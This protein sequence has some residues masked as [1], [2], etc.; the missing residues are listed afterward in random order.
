MSSTATPIEA[1]P[2][3]VSSAVSSNA[4]T[5]AAYPPQPAVPQR[6]GDGVLVDDR[7]ARGIDHAGPRPHPSQRLGVEQVPGVLGQRHQ[8]HHDVAAGQQLGQR[9]LAR[10]EPARLGLGSGIGSLYTS[11]ASKPR[12]RVGHRQAAAVEAR[13][14]PGVPPG[15][16]PG[17]AL[18]QAPPQRQDQ[19]HHQLRR[20]HRQQLRQHGHLHPAPHARCQVDGVVPL[21]HPAD[22]PQPWARRQQ[23][24]IHPVGHAHHK[25][26]G[27]A[28]PGEHIGAWP[29][30]LFARR[31]HRAAEL[32]QPGRHVRM[33]P[34]GDHQCRLPGIARDDLQWL[35][36]K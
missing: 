36:Y 16:H 34:G 10:A 3:A 12:S 6:L 26:V 8:R 14:P 23:L 19:P 13:A 4:N 22:H 11:V 21:E 29:H 9:D 31:R 20:G 35:G 17:V 24:G 30:L 15:A 1:A 7:A 25:A 18:H 33:H 2:G 28:R 27:P 32:G 5:S